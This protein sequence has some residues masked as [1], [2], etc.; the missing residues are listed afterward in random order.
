MKNV[1]IKGISGGEF[2]LTLQDE[3]GVDRSRTRNKKIFQ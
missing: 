2:C 1:A 3:C